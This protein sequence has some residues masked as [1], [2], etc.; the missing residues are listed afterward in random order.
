MQSRSNQ[1]YTHKKTNILKKCFV[2]F[3][4]TL[5]VLHALVYYYI[6][7]YSKWFLQTTIILSLFICLCEDHSVKSTIK[8]QNDFPSHFRY[9]YN[10]THCVQSKAFVRLGCKEKRKSFTGSSQKAHSLIPVQS[11]SCFG[12]CSSSALSGP[13]PQNRLT[14]LMF[15][16]NVTKIHIKAKWFVFT[17]VLC[18]SLTPNLGTASEIFKSLISSTGPI[19]FEIRGKKLLALIPR[20]WI[21]SPANA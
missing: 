3:R 10:N 1:V 21:G 13:T 17:T 11:V 2:F 9:Q 6:L 16:L 18:W 20:K 4:T 15:P 8:F 7:L 12:S 19:A 14:V 5:V